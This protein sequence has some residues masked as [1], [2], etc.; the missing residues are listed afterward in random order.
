M[1]PAGAA[2]PEEASGRRWSAETALNVDSIRSFRLLHTARFKVR[3]YFEPRNRARRDSLASLR[4]RRPM[5]AAKAVRFS[6]FSPSIR[7]CRGLSMAALPGYGEQPMPEIAGLRC[8]PP[9][10]TDRPG[11]RSQSAQLRSIAAT[12]Q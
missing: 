11:R 4:L 10:L 5:R 12:I 8:R 2:M 9:L 6:R 3:G 7:R 1:V